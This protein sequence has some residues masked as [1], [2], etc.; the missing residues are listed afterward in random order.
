M[1]THTHTPYQSVVH[2]WWARGPGCLVLQVLKV[3]GHVLNAQARK[4]YSKDQIS[5]ISSSM[6]LFC[7]CSMKI[8]SQNPSKLSSLSNFEGRT[9]YNLDRGG[10]EREMNQD[11]VDIKHSVPQRGLSTFVPF[12]LILS[13]QM[14]LNMKPPDVVRNKIR[15]SSECI[16]EFVV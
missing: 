11:D 8:P 13:D 4:T 1:D 15:G 16:W 12:N 6:K 9:T 5:A 3:K 14:F 10:W 2:T 7:R